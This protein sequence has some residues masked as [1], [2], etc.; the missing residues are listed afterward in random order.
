MDDDNHKVE[1]VP[2]LQHKSTGDS[3]L[4]DDDIDLGD[5]SYG[6]HKDDDNN[7]KTNTRVSK[8][9]FSHCLTHYMD[10]VKI[11]QQ[12]R[13]VVELVILVEAGT[14]IRNMDPT[15]KLL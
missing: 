6:C 12:N 15:K 3:I 8:Y 7:L 13:K 4:D 9:S 11:S 2:M 10:G 14:T 5:I 1:S